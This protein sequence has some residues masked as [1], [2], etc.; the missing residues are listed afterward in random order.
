MSMLTGMLPAFTFVVFWE[1]IGQRKPHTK[2]G[3][4]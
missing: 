3:T 4:A 1:P 2:A